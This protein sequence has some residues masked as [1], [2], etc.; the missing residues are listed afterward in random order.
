LLSNRQPLPFTQ[1]GGNVSVTL[2][3]QAP[4]A[5]ATVLC[6]EIQ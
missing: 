6:L 2:P 5:L 4:D 3:A 1:D